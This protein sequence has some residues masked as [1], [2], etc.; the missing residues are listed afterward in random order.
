MSRSGFTLE[1][2]QDPTTYAKRP[3]WAIYYRGHDCKLQ[4]CWS[5][6]DGGIDFMMAPPFA[7]NDFGLA[8]RSRTW[9]FM[10]MLSGA[11]DDLDTPSP[12]ADDIAVMSWLKALY[13]AH[14]S[15]AHS[16]LVDGKQK[17]E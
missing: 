1:E 16:K 6:R 8:D 11:H 9:Q 4:I 5:A 13:D 17:S 12:D 7:P 3:A 14:F 10:L 2:V 15:S